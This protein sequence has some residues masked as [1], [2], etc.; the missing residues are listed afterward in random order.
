MLSVNKVPVYNQYDLMREVALLGP[1]A[2]ARLRI[3]RERERRERTISVELGKWPVID[4][5][6]IIATRLR[7]PVWRGLSVDYPTA[8]SKHLPYQLDRYHR[9]VLV[10]KVAVSSAAAGRRVNIKPGDYITHV[11]RVPVTTPAEFA[12]LVSRLSGPV[13]LN[14]ADGRRT[15]LPAQ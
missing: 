13:T 11:N 10:T 12:K 1:G 14:L 8:R 6:G 7:T 2:T 15:L 9:A 3:W 4:E 5:E